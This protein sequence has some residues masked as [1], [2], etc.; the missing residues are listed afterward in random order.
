MLSK[1]VVL[2]DNNNHLFNLLNI[3][4]SVKDILLIDYFLNKN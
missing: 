2:I 3:N 1:F 4:N